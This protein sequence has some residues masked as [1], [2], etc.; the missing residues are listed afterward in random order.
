MEVWHDATQTVGPEY[1]L[2]FLHAGET[3][4]DQMI[5]EWVMTVRSSDL[6]T[7]VEAMGYQ[8]SVNEGEVEASRRRNE[9]LVGTENNLCIAF[10]AKEDQ[11][12]PLAEL[13]RERGTTV[14]RHVQ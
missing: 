13:A 7:G 6:S 5:E 8:G 10:A 14:W 11:K 4:A 9:W 1:H 2:Y 3:A 12:L